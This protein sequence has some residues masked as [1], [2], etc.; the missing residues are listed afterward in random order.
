LEHRLGA[1]GL[2]VAILLLARPETRAE[3]A[4]REVDG[5]HFMTIPAA[6]LPEPR[7]EPP[8]WAARMGH[9]LNGMFEAIESLKV[10]CGKGIVGASNK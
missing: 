9:R 3:Q 5:Q 8:A 1:A 10:A 2:I 4:D 6:G 7:P